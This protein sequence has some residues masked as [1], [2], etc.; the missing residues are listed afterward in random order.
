MGHVTVFSGPERRRRWT[1]EE[2]LSI[3]S[4]AFAPGACVSEVARRRDVSTSLIY[5][6]RRRICDEA[7]EPASGQAPAT[8]FAEAVMVEDRGDDLSGMSPAMMVDLPRGKRVSIFRSASPG[9]VA[10]A[11]KALR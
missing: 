10:A 4:E 6:W 11:L 1:D 9:Q 5:T 7:G 2:R 8:S 3:L